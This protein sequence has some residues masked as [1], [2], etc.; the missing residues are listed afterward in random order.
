MAKLDQDH[1]CRRRPVAEESRDC[2]LIR[3]LNCMGSRIDVG[4][5]DGL[6]CSNCRTA[7]C[8]LLLFHV[9][10]NVGGVLDVGSE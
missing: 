7:L 6:V 1:R 9:H 8:A 4:D 3:F 2:S 5:L 10:S